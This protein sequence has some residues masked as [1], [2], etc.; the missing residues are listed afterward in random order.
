MYELRLNEVGGFSV[1]NVRRDKVVFTCKDKLK[2]F[3]SKDFKQV[4]DLMKY[5]A[6]NS[7]IATYRKVSKALCAW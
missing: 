5:L 3:T 6:T 7:S 4:K 2:T 1:F